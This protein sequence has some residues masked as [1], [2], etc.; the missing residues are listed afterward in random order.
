MALLNRIFPL[1]S[2]HVKWN[3]AESFETWMKYSS[4]ENHNNLSMIIRCGDETDDYFGRLEHCLL[5]QAAV[6]FSSDGNRVLYI[7]HEK[8]DEIPKCVHGMSPPDPSLMKLLKIMYMTETNQLINYLSEIHQN[9]LLPDVLIIHGL[10]WY[11]NKCENDSREHSLARLC[12]LIKNTSQFMTHKSGV[13]SQI[14]VSMKDDTKRVY[15]STCQQFIPNIWKLTKNATKGENETEY[16]LTKEVVSS[17]SPRSS[18][19]HFLPLL[20]D[21]E[22]FETT[23]VDFSVGFEG[24]IVLR[25]IR[26]QHLKD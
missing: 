10:D 23:C 19:A 16:R 2:D 9:S 4:E 6:T 14:L 5:L 20:S 22:R 18:L 11:A 8:F 3:S 17:S 21:V 7:T 1:S 24:N 26:Q 13:N 12:A 25:N 15:S